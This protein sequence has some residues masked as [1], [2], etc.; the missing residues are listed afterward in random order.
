MKPFVV[1]LHQVTVASGPDEETG[2]LSRPDVAFTGASDGYLWPGDVGRRCVL[3]AADKEV[4][5]TLGLVGHDLARRLT[6]HVND[7]TDWESRFSAR[8][9]QARAEPIDQDFP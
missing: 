2:D 3:G 1:H 4:A 9:C 5:N 6:D 8:S 7:I